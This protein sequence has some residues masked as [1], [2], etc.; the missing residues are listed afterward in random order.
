MSSLLPILFYP[1]KTILI[2]ALLYGYY[3]IALRDASFHMYNRWYLL[4]TVLLSLLLPVLPIPGWLSGSFPAKGM[5]DLL[6]GFTVVAPGDGSG[7]RGPGLASGGQAGGFSWVKL[8]TGGYLL[9]AG[10]FL[11]SLVRSLLYL[12]R[13]ARKYPS[14]RVE[15]IRVFMTDEPGAPFSFFRTIFWNRGLDIGSSRGGQVFRHERYH[16]RQLHS[17]DILSLELIRALAWYNPFF[18]LI[19]RELKAVH[20][21][22]ADRH[23]L[24]GS[25][26]H[27]YAELLLF[28][29]LG[30]QPLP[31]AHSF[32]H[33][34]LKRRIYMITNSYR[35]QTGYW[36][37]VMVLPLLVLVFCA[38]S[39][40]TPARGAAADLHG[41]LRSD[42]G[43]KTVNAV[44][45]FYLHHLR[46]PAAALAAGQE[47]TIWFAVKIGKN[48]ELLAFQSFEQAPDL[49][50]KRSF[51]ITVKS[52]PA[53]FPDAKGQVLT[54]ENRKTLFLQEALKVSSDLPS[55]GKNMSFE[56]GEYFFTIIFKLEKRVPGDSSLNLFIRQDFPDSVPKK[57]Q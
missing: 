29:G 38:V 30:N 36:G 43:W 4:G 26:Q 54:E 7:V 11:Y 52:L 5:T 6:Q 53:R 33:S 42:T 39:S 1:A 50:G 47:N 57:D 22:M 32:F 20:E 13:V 48:A 44:T 23:A 2:A 3:R 12:V 37:R 27:E 28:Q 51:A 16:I 35:G 41:P 34:H 31:V 19:L 25:C 10:L 46:Y 24:A 8:V 40:G 21:F 55:L 56:P 45:R 17:I 18:H 9:I 14:Q 15:D 49:K